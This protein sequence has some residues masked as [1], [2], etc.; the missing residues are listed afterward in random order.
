MFC[1]EVKSVIVVE[2]ECDTVS[3]GGSHSADPS[4][5]SEAANAAELMSSPVHRFSLP[6]PA[7]LLLSSFLLC[8]CEAELVQFSRASVVFINTLF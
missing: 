8:L 7:L 5:L 2:S 3:P 1:S 6:D 4:R